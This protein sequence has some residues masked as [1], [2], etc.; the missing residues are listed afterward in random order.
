MCTDWSQFLRSMST[1]KVFLVD[2]IHVYVEHKPF[3]FPI[4]K[5]ENKLY[6]IA[7]LCLFFFKLC[8]S[9]ARD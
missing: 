7:L 9:K 2:D 8:A 3:V 4:S 5:N 1:G 6:M